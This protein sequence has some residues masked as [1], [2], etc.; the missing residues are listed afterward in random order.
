MTI[1][2]QIAKAEKEAKRMKFRASEMRDSWMLNL[3]ES[4]IEI[5]KELKKEVDSLKAN[6]P[7]QG[8]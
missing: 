2:E 6:K 4:I 7:R 1:A 3:C 8:Q 5:V